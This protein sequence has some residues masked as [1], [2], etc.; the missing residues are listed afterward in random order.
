MNVDVA[1]GVGKAPQT[2]RRGGPVGHGAIKV[3]NTEICFE[4]SHIGG[5]S[6]DTR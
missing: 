1:C 6:S 5:R 3:E 2:P 4:F